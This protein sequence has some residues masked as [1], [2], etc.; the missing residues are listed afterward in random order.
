MANTR[1]DKEALT[2]YDLKDEYQWIRMLGWGDEDLQRVTVSEEFPAGQEHLN[3]S[4]WGGTSLGVTADY[5]PTSGDARGLRNIWVLKAGAPDRL[6][7]ELQKI[8]EQ[9]G[10]SGYQS[11]GRAG[12]KGEVDFPPR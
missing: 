2:L 1:S 11:G 8:T 4:N 6:W 3:V 12:A 10:P 7:K 5:G 9:G